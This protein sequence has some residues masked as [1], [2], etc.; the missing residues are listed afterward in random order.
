MGVG[1]RSAMIQNH[2]VDNPFAQIKHSNNNFKS[3]AP[4]CG[5]MQV[6]LGE[7][8]CTHVARLGAAKGGV[9]EWPLE[10]RVTNRKG[11]EIKH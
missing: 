6:M 9:P 1:R 4:I 8:A 2:P 10:V 11:I 5:V 7:L 3:L